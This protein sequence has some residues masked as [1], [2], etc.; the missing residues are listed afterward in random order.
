MAASLPYPDPAWARRLRSLTTMLLV[1]VWPFFAFASLFAFDASGAEDNPFN[2]VFIV[3]VLLYLPAWATSRI[4]RWLLL[5]EGQWRAA[6]WV[7]LLPLVNVV[8]AGVAIALISIVCDG[9]LVCN[10]F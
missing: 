9:E 2:V 10:V 4:I 8:A 3:A 5:K 7:D 1:F 6:A